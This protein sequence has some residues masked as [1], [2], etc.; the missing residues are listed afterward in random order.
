MGNLTGRVA[1]VTGAA[2]GIGLAIAGTL[3][4]AGAQVVTTDI[5]PAQAPV[6]RFLAHDVTSPEQWA[7][8]LATVEREFGRL[9]VL[10]NNAGIVH[11]APVE[12]T[13]LEDWRRVTAVNVDGVFLGVKAALPLMRAS[14]AT[15]PF[16]GSIINVSS[17]AGLVGAPLFSAYCMSKGAVRL[18]T[19]ATA[20][21]FGVLG[22]KIRVNSVHPGGVDTAMMDRIYARA[23]EQGLVESVEAARAGVVATHPLGRLANPDDIAKVVRFLASDDAG[24]M[25]GSEVVVDGGHTAI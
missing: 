8:V 13:S 25:T 21:E 2:N 18:F 7:G 3:E 9:D 10:V 20:A 4:A 24:Y 5:V 16:G 17:V 1:L 11:S 15:T 19:K 22:H 14:A 12:T 6:G 23:V